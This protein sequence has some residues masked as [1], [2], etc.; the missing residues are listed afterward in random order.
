MLTVGLTGGIASGKTTVSR[1]LEEKG[2]VVADADVLA[3][4]L[5]D[6]DVSL[7][8]QV[9]AEFGD[10]AVVGGR[11]DRKHLGELVFSDPERLKALNRLVHPL[12]IE[13]VE[14]ILEG[15]RAQDTAPFGVVQVP[16][17]IEAGMVE[18]FDKIV[19]IVSS[20]EQ[21]VKRLLE[22]G[23]TEDEALSRL[24]S[25]LQDWERLPFADLTLINKGNLKV[26]ASESDR[27]FRRLEEMATEDGGN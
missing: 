9:A 17:L 13:R 1:I 11:I 7:R 4:E 19:V 18:M 27:L 5:M 10:P 25:Q 16:L 8:A 22:A 6:G 24:S 26:L 21:Q 20:P 15:W 3:H 12:V 14:R 23:L 2:A